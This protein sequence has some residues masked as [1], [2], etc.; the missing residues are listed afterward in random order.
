MGYVTEWLTEIMSRPPQSVNF[1]DSLMKTMLIDY[2]RMSITLDQVILRRIGDNT[3]TT[4]EVK[5]TKDD[6]IKLHYIEIEDRE[7][8]QYQLNL[9]A[10]KTMQC[11]PDYK[12]ELVEVDKVDKR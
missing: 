10:L 2:I 8:K 6:V 11:Y 12:I 5:L 4:I 3:T 7:W 1:E 9:A